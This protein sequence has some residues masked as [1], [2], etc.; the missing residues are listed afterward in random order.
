METHYDYIIAGA[1]CA[2]LSLAYRMSLDTYFNDKKIL[3]ID[4]EQKTK[5]DRTWCFWDKDTTAFDEI[6]TKQW[7][8]LTYFGADMQRA[9]QIA[10]YQYKM[11][12]S[13]QFYHFCLGKINR[14]KNITALQGDISDM[15][16]TADATYIVVDEKKIFANKIFS[17]ILLQEPNLSE[18]DIYLLQHFKGWI[19]ETAEKKFDDQKAILMDFRIDQ[20]KG[21]AFVY[22]L[23]L[24]SKKALVEFTMFSK[25]ILEDAQYDIGLKQYINQ[26]LDITN[27][28]IVE[29]EFGIIPMTNYQ[30]EAQQNNIHFIGIAGGAA[31]P[32]SG[33][34]FTFIQKQVGKIIEQLKQNKKVDTRD[35]HPKRFLF[36]DEVLLYLIQSK[37]LSVEAIFSKLFS[38]NSFATIFTFLHNE[39]SIWQEIKLMNTVQRW[40]FI[41]AVWQRLFTK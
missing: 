12:R 40:V 35:V 34:T 2:G 14:A 37:K 3:L 7:N 18:S 8:H 22:T 26:H 15:Q 41:K 21:A 20:S 24:S 25:E 28:T 38:G 39:T 11:I 27:F 10:P 6:I 30:F 23:P 16:S 17:S 32:S 19:I 36:Y 31:K 29:K 13:E 9:E 1:G 33:Y 5:Q 4:K